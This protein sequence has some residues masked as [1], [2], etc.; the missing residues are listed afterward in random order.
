MNMKKVMPRVITALILIAA[1]LPP[2]IIGGKA[3]EVLALVF[4]VLASY[5]IASIKNENKAD[6]VLTVFIAAVIE[7]LM[8]LPLNLFAAGISI[9]LTILF[10]L[11]IIRE[12]F[13]TNQAVYTFVIA[14][15]VCLAWR[16]AL[17]IYD[18][19]S[20]GTTMIFVAVCCYV[21]DTGAWLF[22]SLFGKH[23]MIP[24]ISPNKTWEGSAGGYCLGAAVGLIFGLLLIKDLPSSLIIAASFILP[25]IAQIGDLAFSSIKREWGMKDFGSL[26]PGHG[27][28]LDRIDSLVFCLMVFNALMLIWGV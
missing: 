26:L 14:V 20:G 28:V 1:V 27:G 16:G 21:C 17:R 24:R 2:F 5:E 22:G 4:T 13:T 6:W 11:H 7:I 9:F 18:G 23:K 10:L 15:I 12:D 25:A 3:I 8:H 19:R